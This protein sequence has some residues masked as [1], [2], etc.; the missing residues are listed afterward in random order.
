MNKKLYNSI[1]RGISESLQKSL[2]E[3]LFDDVDDILSNDDIN[4]SQLMDDYLKKVILETLCTTDAYHNVEADEDDGLPMIKQNPDNSLQYYIAPYTTYKR[5]KLGPRK[6]KRYNLNY[7]YRYILTFD[8]TGGMILDITKF[9]NKRNFIINDQLYQFICKTPYTISEIKYHLPYNEYT[10]YTEQWEKIWIIDRTPLSKPK[11][12]PNSFVNNFPE[13]ITPM[14]SDELKDDM[15]PSNNSIIDRKWFTSDE[16]FLTFIQKL[17]NNQFDISDK[18]FFVYNQNTIDERRKEILSGNQDKQIEEENDAKLNF[19]RSILG[20][21][22]YQKFNQILQY[23]QENNIKFYLKTINTFRTCKICLKDTVL[24]LRRQN[25]YIFDEIDNIEEPNR[26]EPFFERQLLYKM[27]CIMKHEKLNDWKIQQTYDECINGTVVSYNFYNTST[28]YY[29]INTLPIKFDNKYAI[30]NLYYV[31][32][33]A[34]SDSKPIYELG[35]KKFDKYPYQNDVT[36][37]PTSILAANEIEKT[38]NAS[39]NMST[40][41]YSYL[42]DQLKTIIDK[43]CKKYKIK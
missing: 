15:N 37:G 36:L 28:S 39:F 31:I 18:E 27:F 17:V 32:G 11:N 38:G 6:R 20:E 14:Y 29:D 10:P 40:F 1:V 26:V 22:Y 8:E 23:F 3:G 4:S 7:F 33:K 5:E 24:N 2:Y 9:G 13:K 21:K 35:V 16:M 42:T 41:D 30:Y 12:I 34:I 19:S 25:G 43:V